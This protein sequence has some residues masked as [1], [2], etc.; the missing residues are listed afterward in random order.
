MMESEYAGKL[1]IGE[2]AETPKII[3]VLR[4]DSNCA[5]DK[6]YFA[7]SSLC[8][9]DYALVSFQQSISFYN[10]TKY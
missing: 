2:Q 8:E 4:L 7:D 6:K 9:Q 1:S 5:R 3:S 10:L